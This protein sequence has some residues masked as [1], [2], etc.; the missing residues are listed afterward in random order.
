MERMGLHMLDAQ[1]GLRTLA[2]AVGAVAHSLGATGLG[3]RLETSSRPCAAS[4]DAQSLLYAHAHCKS[5]RPRNWGIDIDTRSLA[6]RHGHANANVGTKPN[7]F[8][9][10]LRLLQKEQAVYLALL[11]GH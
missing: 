11:R 8:N 4:A 3:A 1:Q 10:L 5:T 2:A 7:L 9:A 6:S